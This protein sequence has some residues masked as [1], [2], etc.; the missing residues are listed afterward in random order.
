MFYLSG[1][2][3]LAFLR[4]AIVGKS[5]LKM[6]AISR[7]NGK[8]LSHWPILSGRVRENDINQSLVGYLLEVSVK[9]P[10]FGYTFLLPFSLNNGVFLHWG[11]AGTL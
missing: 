8:Q 4:F 5:L 3:W 9:N 2:F 1:L 10:L 6:G 11:E 7:K